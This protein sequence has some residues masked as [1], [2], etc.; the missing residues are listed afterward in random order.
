MYAGIVL[1]VSLLLI[2]C[3]G[4][5]YHKRQ[6]ID[7]AV[8]E[9]LTNSINRSDKIAIYLY[10]YE[11][12]QI[13]I[14]VD[15]SSPFFEKL[16]NSLRESL[17]YR[18]LYPHGLSDHKIVFSSIADGVLAEVGVGDSVWIDN[19]AYASSEGTVFLSEFLELLDKYE[20]FYD[21]GEPKAEGGNAYGNRDGH[22]RF[23]YKNGSKMAEGD[24]YKGVMVREWKYWNA[25][26]EPS[27]E[28]DVD[29][30][31]RRLDVR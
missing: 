13:P 11:P 17:R 31:T 6:A 10:Y 30:A 27:K 2:P 18:N 1:C 19:V 3:I 26:G 9:N 7:P 4:C 21:S 15:R 28:F 8:V 12:N 20:Y 22:W 14:I 29:E 5:C 24:Y 16:S 23:Y 25:N